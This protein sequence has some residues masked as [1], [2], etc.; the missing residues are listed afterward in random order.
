[1]NTLRSTEG[2]SFL[3]ILV[4]L[5]ILVVGVTSIFGLFS[6]ATYS[7]RRS[8]NDALVTRMTTTIFSELESGKHP[9]SVDFVDCFDQTHP[10]FPTNYTYDL[11]LERVINTE[12]SSR[13][14]TLTIKS[15]RLKETFI[16]FLNFPVQ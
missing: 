3:E 6:T 7:H 5:M 16:T 10:Q 4:A 1:M 11:L 13:L 12:P 9:S 8:L 2:F 14:V 15:N